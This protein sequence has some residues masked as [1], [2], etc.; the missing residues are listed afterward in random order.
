MRK[1]IAFAVVIALVLVA[2]GCRKVKLEKF[3]EIG[4]S[5]TAFVVQLEGD[6]GVKFDSVESLQKLQVATKRIDIAQRWKK[7]GR[8]WFSGDWIPTTR[9]IKV[10]RSPV[11]REWTADAARG[12]S[13]VNQ[14]IW[15]ESS[16]SITFSTGFNCTARVREEDAATY[17]YNFPS[18]TDLA[19]IMDSQIRNAIQGVAAEV[20]AKYDMDD[21]RDK[22]T[23][24]IA[25]VRK[26]VVPKFAAYGITI[27]PTDL[28]MFGG[29]EYEDPE[30]QKA[31]NEVFV[32]QQIKEVAAA[33]LE[34]QT[35]KNA[36]IKM[37]ATGK[38]DAAIEEASG[39]AQAI[40]I[41]AEAEAAAIEAVHLAAEKAKENELFYKL[42]LVEVDL[43]RIQG[44]D[45]RL[46]QWIMG[47][48]GSG[49]DLL[50]TPPEMATR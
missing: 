38:A 49:M 40:K 36:T 31:I 16:D 25:E 29:F 10:L 3:E 11:T 13:Q 46:P 4:E 39:K 44:W 42:K 2:S 22:K 5:E 43:A 12:T 37:A 47:N 17:L 15:I 7:T 9:V 45:G 14:G 26:Q 35:D 6:T 50:V 48:G 24:L 23:E 20:A 30:I 19:T 27:E 28:G 18:G 21:C 41:E 34:A 33:E 32:A 8:L 1:R